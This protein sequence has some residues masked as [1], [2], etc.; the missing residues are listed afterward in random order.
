MVMEHKG[1]SRP[2]YL[3]HLNSP[4]LLLNSPLTPVKKEPNDQN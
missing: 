3:P 1:A 4:P 2:E